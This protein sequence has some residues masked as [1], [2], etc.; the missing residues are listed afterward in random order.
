MSLEQRN[1]GSDFQ[2]HCQAQLRHKS[3]HMAIAARFELRTGVGWTCDRI[4]TQ[5]NAR[6]VPRAKISYQTCRLS[7]FNGSLAGSRQDGRIES[8]YLLKHGV[9]DSL[10]NVK[11]IGNICL[12][13]V[14]ELLNS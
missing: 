5:Q 7:E 13:T 8:H 14:R 1:R 10:R 11:S 9:K 2:E 4:G 3:I 6:F 12:R